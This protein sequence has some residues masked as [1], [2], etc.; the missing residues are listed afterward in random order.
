MAVPISP[1]KQRRWLLHLALT[2]SSPRSA[3]HRYL[4]AFVKTPKRDYASTAIL[5]DADTILALLPRWINDQCDAQPSSGLKYRSPQEF[6][7]VSA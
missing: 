2:C 5:P 6:L 3:E 7:R 1:G 4:R